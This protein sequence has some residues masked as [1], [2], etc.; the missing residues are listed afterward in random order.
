[1]VFATSIQRENTHRVSRLSQ[2]KCRLLFFAESAQFTRAACDYLLRNLLL[3]ICR[4]RTRTRRKRKNVQVGEREPF[5]ERER[6][7]MVCLG[8][9]G[10][11]SNHVRA[12]GRVGE[13]FAREFRMAC[14]MLGAIPAMHCRKDAVGAG[15]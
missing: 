5:N 13:P 1:M 3:Q 6:G 9:S 11:S 14:V 15:L 12:D 8:L 7:L 10:K 2:L 4:R